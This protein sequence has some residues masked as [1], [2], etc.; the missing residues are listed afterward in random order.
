[1]LKTPSQD[2][3]KFTV[4]WSQI[5]DQTP[6][7]LELFALWPSPMTADVCFR[8]AGFSRFGDGDED[9]ESHAKELLTRLLCELE[10]YGEPSLTSEPIERHQSLLKRFFIKNKPLSLREQI[11][12]RTVYDEFPDCVVAFGSSGVSL[13]TGNGHHI[14]WIAVPHTKAAEFVKTLPQIAGE[15]EFIRTD[16]KW[17]RLFAQKLKLNLC[18]KKSESPRRSAR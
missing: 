15:H 12:A 10:K 13:R 3:Q 14:F 17:D 4:H 11:E 8:E 18:Q 7:G 9:W 6:N 5:L 16:L 2:I 1:M